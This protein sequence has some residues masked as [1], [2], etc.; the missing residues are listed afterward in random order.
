MNIFDTRLCLQTRFLLPFCLFIFLTGGRMLLANDTLSLRVD[1]AIINC[2]SV[3]FFDL[4]VKSKGAVGIESFSFT[5][6]WNNSVADFQQT[7]NV[8]PILASGLTFGL[9]QVGD[10]Y[11]N[12]SWS[13]PA[14]VSLPANEVLFSVHFEDVTQGNAGT[15]VSFIGFPTIISAMFPSGPAIVLTKSG[16]VDIDDDTEPFVGNC[17]DDI[18]VDAVAGQ[19]TQ[20]VTW[21]DLVVMDACD[22]NLVVTQ[23]H[24][25]GSVFNIGP[26]DVTFTYLDNG[27]NVTVCS[28][29]VRVVDN[30]DPMLIGCPSSISRYA[31]A[32]F[33]GANVSW[34]A[35]TASDDCDNDVIV[36]SDHVNGGMFDVGVNQVTYTATDNSN[37][38]GT[39]TFNVTVIDTIAPILIC[40]DT[41]FINTTPGLCTGVVTWPIVVP[42]ENCTLG[43][44]STSILQNVVFSPGLY[45]NMVTATDIFNNVSH[46][47]FKIKVRDIVL[48]LVINCPTSQ[49]VIAPG[50]ACTRTVTWVAPTATDNCTITGISSN[51]T[52]G[53]S[54]SVGSKVVTY[55]VSDGTNIVTCSFTVVVQDTTKPVITGCPANLTVNL[56]TGTC[57]VAVAW[58]LPTITDNCGANQMSV[59]NT[60]LP[61]HI[62]SPGV[63]TNNIVATDTSGNSKTC[64]FNINVQDVSPPVISGC[65]TDIV[66]NLDNSCFAVA[67]WTAPTATDNCPITWLNN[68]SSGTGLSLGTTNVYYIAQDV[69]GN[70]DTCQFSVALNDVGAPSITCPADMTV[71]SPN[72]QALAIWPTADAVDACDNAPNIVS[73]PS[74]GT[75]LSLGQHDVVFTAT[76]NA[77]NANECH[78]TV[79]V[80]ETTPPTVTCPATIT[81]GAATNSCTGVATWQ[82]PVATDN[83][84]GDDIFSDWQS[85]SAFPLGQT[86]VTYTTTDESGNSGTCSFVVLVKDVT[87]PTFTNCQAN[88]T[89]N[90]TTTCTKTISWN[91]PN[92]TDNCDASLSIAESHPN[93][94]F[95]FP[96]GVTTV[97][98]VATDD[99]GNTAT[100]S[101]KVTIN[102]VGAPV[103]TN[104]PT[105]PVIVGTNTADCTSLNN[106]A[107]PTA[108]DACDSQLD[109]TSNITPDVELSVGIHPV[110]YTFTDN[111]GNSA[112]CNFTLV[113]KDLLPPTFT[114]CPSDI[115][116]STEP[117]M[118]AAVADWTEPIPADNCEIESLATNIQPGNNLSV[119]EYEV[120]YFA[121]DYTPNQASCTFTVTVVDL[122]APIWTN[123]PTDITANAPAGTCEAAVD[124]GSIV[125]FDNCSDVTYETDMASGSVFPLGE[126]TVTVTATDELG[127]STEAAFVVTVEDVTPPTITCPEAITVK[128]DGTIVSDASN[129][130]TSTEAVSC[131]QVSINTNTPISTDDCTPLLVTT[132]NPNNPTTFAI[133]QTTISYTAQDNS[134]NTSSC[135]VNITVEGIPLV[136]NIVASANPICSGGEVTVSIADAPEGITFAWAGPSFSSTESNPSITDFGVANAG[137]YTVTIQDTQGCQATGTIAIAL[138]AQPNVTISGTTQVC[139]GDALGLLADD[140]NNATQTWSWTGPNTSA[141]STIDIVAATPTDGGT[142]TLIG[143]SNLGCC[144]TTTLAV[145]VTAIQSG[146]TISPANSNLCNGESSTLIGTAVAIGVGTWYAEPTTGAGLPTNLNTANITVTPTANSV[147]YFYFIENNGCYSDTASATITSSSVPDFSPTFDAADCLQSG[148]ALSLYAPT[149]GISSYNWAGPNS[150]AST[151]ANPTITNLTA[152]NTGTYTVTVTDANNCTASATVQV[153]LT[154][155]PAAPTVDASNNGGCAGATIELSAEGIGGG[156]F[157]W[158]GPNGEI[159]VGQAPL[160][161]NVGNN[162][163]GEYTCIHTIGACVSPPSEPLTVTIFTDVPTATTDSLDILDNSTGQTIDLLTNDTYLAG[164]AVVTHIASEP[165]LG[166]WSI[167]P[168]GQATYVPNG[169]Y[170]GIMQATYSLCYEACPSL[171]DTGLIWTVI[172]STALLIPSIITPNGD[173]QNDNFLIPGLE[174]Q[175]AFPENELYIYNE[176]GD[177]IYN[178]AP[179]QNDWKGTYKDQP[180]PDGTYFYVFRAAP[181]AEWRKG[182]ITVFR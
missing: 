109:V 73:V 82:P 58:A 25:S 5:L 106:W 172:N 134:G 156:T 126:T 28:F 127:N 84:I 147:Q 67:G 144:D 50:S 75:S 110:E 123:P 61:S 42:N 182:F 125:A 15:A 150:F 178:A 124:Y 128:T 151:E 174:S 176:W 161:E 136:A 9:T 20:T 90:L 140:T 93:E 21:P 55:S 18:Y 153:S 142:Y 26:T 88:V 46:C 164:F 17:P 70:R 173:G 37:N 49:T 48:P 45:T 169:T 86:V 71:S 108:T 97:S 85:G 111:S 116:V 121:L 40:P 81:V 122:S 160:L 137:T 114:F 6:Q 170:A 135:Q 181:D 23:S 162:Q 104:C 3:D 130:V 24:Y 115:T 139:Q 148:D 149:T 112:T 16:L 102:E 180:V 101:F 32:S 60:Y 63:Y 56:P 118:C 171:C 157:T 94:I 35:P 100:C 31:T 179:Y 72:C 107:T 80:T 89:F 12:V 177:E 87:A 175:T 53:Q 4:N 152:S 132:P 141:N 65:P 2:N 68:I 51:Y 119:G 167:Y 29:T 158:T 43:Q 77:G 155:T 168:D 74:S 62:F 145:S 113:V 34:V 10:G 33:C 83:C 69:S 78:F 54:F 1:T 66:I 57:S 30:T 27:F 165:L 95:N 159:I 79:T 7:L 41:V 154:F 39:C 166:I 143:C 120:V 13:N 64:S 38:T 19:C 22:N 47:S 105:T 92:F 96:T 8:N 52:S 11:L 117:N 14:G 103:I 146:L 163:V 59:T 131:T 138:A 91:A 133:G 36:L 99:A 44:Y 129:F 76:D 98:Y